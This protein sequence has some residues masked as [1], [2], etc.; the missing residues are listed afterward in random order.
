MPTNVLMDNWNILWI[1]R[2]SDMHSYNTCNK[3]AIRLPKIKYNWGK[4]RSQYHCFKDFDFNELERTVRNSASLP[5][6]KKCLFLLLLIKFS[7]ISIL[8]LLFLDFNCIII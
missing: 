7:Y 8:A 5:M 6:F 1:V 3:D 4:H 2:K